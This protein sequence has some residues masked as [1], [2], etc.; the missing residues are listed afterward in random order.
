[1]KKKYG[2]SL[3][4]GSARGLAH[5]GVL[6]ALLDAGIRPKAVAGASMGAI[7]GA[8]YAAGVSPQEMPVFF[9]KASMLSYF[10]WRLPSHGGMLS[11]DKL[12]DEL[13]QVLGVTT[14]EE[15]PI[16]LCVSVTNF[17]RGKSEIISNGALAL[18]IAASAAIPLVFKPVL[19]NGDLYVDGGI[20][21]SQPL[22]F[23][24]K[25]C[26]RNIAS[27][28]NYISSESISTTFKD[29]AERTYKLAL[30]ENVKPHL[31]KFCCVINPPELARI[32]LFDFQAIDQIV[33]IGYTETKRLIEKG[34]LR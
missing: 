7:V 11:S 21:N 26:R 13:D 22:G 30:Y 28:V 8:L 1:M 34:T 3:S 14:F 27:Y 5:I 6:Q 23:L 4:G 10:S 17:T 33:Q 25:L 20:T 29:V 31:R 18:A 19:M 24:P 32:R 16:P 15:L 12:A 9:K 2:I